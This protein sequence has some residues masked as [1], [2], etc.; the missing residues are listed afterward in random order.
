FSS[1]AHPQYTMHLLRKRSSWVVPVILCDR[2][3]CSDHGEEEREMWSRMMVILFVSW[4]LP[5]E[6]KA[7]NESWCTA[8][9]RYREV[10][11]TSHHEII[12]HMNV[13]SECRDARDEFSK[14]R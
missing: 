10:I 5:S 3:P 1:S 7:N 11:S 2:V 13:L 14:K 8:Y 12:A 4:R 6:V 9:D